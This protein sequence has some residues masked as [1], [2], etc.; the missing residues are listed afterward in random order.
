MTDGIRAGAGFP[1]YG[2]RCWGLTASY[3]PKGYSAHSPSNDLGVISPTAAL[4][5]MPYTPKESM[6]MLE[7][8][9][10]HRGMLWDEYGPIDAFAT[11]FS[12]M[13]HRYLAIDQ[14]PIAPMIENHR[15]GLLWNLFMNCPEIIS[16]TGQGRKSRG[17]SDKK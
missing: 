16:A 3:S 1:L 17:F 8:L 4:S 15:S 6:Q 12:W 14:L 9:W 7:F 13:P 2:S 11:D 10:S 5:S